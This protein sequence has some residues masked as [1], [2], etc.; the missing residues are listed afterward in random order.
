MSTPR[1]TRGER[2]HRPTDI[3]TGRP[4][5]R[6]SSASWTP[7]CPLPISRTPPGGS[8]AG[9]RRVEAARRRRDERCLEWPSGD[10]HVSCVDGSAARRQAESRRA[11]VKPRQPRDVRVELDGRRDRRGIGPEVIDELVPSHVSVGVVA[12]VL[13]PRHRRRPVGRH[14]L[15]RVPAVLPPATQRRPPIEDDVLAA[16]LAEQPAHDQAGLTGADHRRLDRSPLLRHCSSSHC[17]P[18]GSPDHESGP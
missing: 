4:A 17:S 18:W 14:Q 13:K 7:D 6:N 9:L 15:E 16:G 11:V 2:P 3:V 8:C 10:D 12:A 5:S 1:Y